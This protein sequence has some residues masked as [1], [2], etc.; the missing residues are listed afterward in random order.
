MLSSTEGIWIPV[1][2]TQTQ[3]GGGNESA[4]SCPKIQTYFAFLKTWFK[5]S[6]NNLI[7]CS[8]NYKTDHHINTREL[9][10]GIQ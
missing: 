4:I 3:N 9:H 10:M 1:K 5:L 2:H 7:D 8:V 6:N